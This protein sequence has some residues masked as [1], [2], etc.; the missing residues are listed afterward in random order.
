MSTELTKDWIQIAPGVKRQTC[1]VGERMMQVIVF[2][3]KGAKLPEHAH[4]HEQ[5]VSVL[6]GRLKMT[7]AGESQELGD[8]QALA[9]KSNIPHA[10]EAL[11]ETWVL[12]TFSPLREDILKQDA[13]H[14]G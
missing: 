9:L 13:E 4:V 2:Y 6:S 3:E 7:I 14:K 8:G 10:A 11:A 12:D 5:L 1:A